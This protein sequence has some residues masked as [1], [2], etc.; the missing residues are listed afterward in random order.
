MVEKT[1]KQCEM[2]TDCPIC[3]ENY[4]SGDR[5]PMMNDVCRHNI[6]SDCAS[7][8]ACNQKCPLCN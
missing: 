3:L 6:C 4:N 2:D 7:N 8:E 1:E 5:V